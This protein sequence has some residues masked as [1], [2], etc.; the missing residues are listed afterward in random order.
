MTEYGR[1][2]GSPP[3]HP[4]DPLYGDQGWDGQQTADGR[5]PYGHQ[6]PGYTDAY[7]QHPQ[8]QY[9]QHE[10]PYP[11]QQQ[12]QQPYQQQQHQQ[13]QP[14]PQ[15]QQHQQQ[16]QQWDAQG[17]HHPGEP[18]PG[19]HPQ[20]GGYPDQGGQQYTQGG[21]PYG[22]EGGPQDTGQGHA[23]PGPYG[24]GPGQPGDPYG[25]PGPGVHPQQGAAPGHPQTGGPDPG[26]DPG[27]HRFFAGRPDS[28][29][30]RRGDGPGGD[31]GFGSSGGPEGPD[32][33]GDPYGD[34]DGADGEGDHHAG[35]AGDAPEPGGRRGARPRK[36]RSGV[37]CLFVAVALGGVAAGGGWFV[38][39]FYQTRFGPAPDFS[40]NGSGA[41]A[42][43]IPPGAGS[44][45]M[46][47]ILKEAGVVMSAQAFVDAAGDNPKGLSIQPGVYSMKKKMSGEAAVAWMLSPE[48]R[49]TLIIPEG[50]RN[51]QIY[52]TIDK[53][54]ELKQGTTAGIA[55]KQAG[56][57]GLPDWADDDAEIKDPLEGFLYPARYD[58][59]EDAKP[60]DVLKKMVARATAEYEK[61][62]VEAGAEKANLD[63]PLE[64]V[65]V[66]SLV[67]AEG[68]TSDDFRKMARVVYNRLDPG[69]QE[70]AGRL[71][72][73][74]A[75]NY[76]KGQSEIN[77]GIKEIRN[78]DDPYNTYFYRGLPPGPIA[79]P[80]A[81][82]LK[83]A[84]DP[85]PG[86]WYYFVSVDGDTTEFAETHEEHEKLRQRFNENQRN[87]G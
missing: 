1:G 11:Q 45:E 76:L 2:G 26:G 17:G 70:T 38:Y 72:F 55:E 8:Q 9:H 74:S 28:A 51:A 31:G 16:Y 34:E 52:A 78:H 39:D 12:Q 19:H 48:S 42:V 7:Q 60:A 15:H 6:D 4:E 41:V 61:L 64:L 23:A 30:G 87:K 33:P 73:D 36:R 77:I 27:E 13:Q 80:G 46:G 21:Y 24:A 37:A 14:Y 3:W 10:Q 65:T 86:D 53:R 25:H 68:K 40:G 59:A 62:D 63:S 44:G 49:S 58:L 85:E 81:D 54:L 22:W 5:A 43:E 57:L 84:M 67:Q 56:D 20:Q 66:A 47:R 83:A 32:G 18:H 35:D 82:A 79:N 71:E 69:N 50:M 75:F 29:A